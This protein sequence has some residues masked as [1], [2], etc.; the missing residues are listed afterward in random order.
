MGS[1]EYLHK[2]ITSILDGVQWSASGNDHFTPIGKG[3]WWVPQLARTLWRDK[4]LLCE[5]ST[6]FLVV[7]SAAY[8][9]AV[10][11]EPPGTR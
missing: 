10:L 1:G 6:D 5:S 11:T 7:Q 2:F 3:G 4:T 9:V 8:I